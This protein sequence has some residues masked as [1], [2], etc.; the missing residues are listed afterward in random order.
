LWTKCPPPSKLKEYV[1]GLAGQ[2][3]SAD[4]AHA[5]LRAI[6]ENAQA[7]N[8]QNFGNLFGYLQ[9]VLADH[10][11]LAITKIFERASTQYEVR[12]IA[13][14]L[15]VLEEVASSV[16]ILG[17]QRLLQAL[18]SHGVDSAALKYANDEEL[19]RVVVSTYRS[20]LPDSSKAKACALSAALHSWR[21]H[22]DKR[23][24]HDEVTPSN[25]LPTITWGESQ[26]LL[27]VA[28]EFIGVIGW[29]Y[30]STAYIMNENRFILTTDAE[31]DGVALDRLLVMAGLREDEDA[32]LAP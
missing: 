17:R 1:N 18:A 24:A 25:S 12:S 15:A 7:L 9:G 11:G 14:T 2:V 30:L 13:S 26:K 19:T 32:G 21:T 4:R 31:R 29:G 6:G 22:R 8:A 3:L 20:L 23:V 28:K 10:L 16:P 27:D 5:I